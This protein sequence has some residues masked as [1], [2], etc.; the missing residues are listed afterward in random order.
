MSDDDTKLTRPTGGC[1]MNP[2]FAKSLP[3]EAMCEKAREIYE[4]ADDCPIGAGLAGT[5]AE[6][7]GMNIQNNVHWRRIR[8]LLDD[9]FIMKEPGQRMK[10]VY[11]IGIGIVAAVPFCFQEERGLVLY[12]SRSTADV[13]SL[14]HASNE[15]CLLGSTDLIGA[16]HV[17]R[18]ARK[19]SDERRENRH[20]KSL[21][22][23][24]KMFI[25]ETKSLAAMVLNKEDIEELR[26][27]RQREMEVSRGFAE[28]L[29]PRRLAARMSCAVHQFG[30]LI[31]KRIIIS[32]RKWGGAKLNGPPRKSMIDCLFSGTGAFLTMLALLKMNQSLQ[33]DGRIGFDAGWYTSTLC[34]VFALTPASVG[35][36][37]HIFLAHLWNMLVGLACREIPT[38][39][40]Y[41]LPLMWVQALAVALGISGQA[42]IGNLH[43][44]ATGLSMIFASGPKWT[45]STIVAVMLADTVVVII[46]ML[47]INLSE[48]GQYP[49]YWVGLGWA[50][51]GGTKGV[52]KSKVRSLRRSIAPA[53][54]QSHDGLRRRP[55]DG[56]QYKTSYGA[57]SDLPV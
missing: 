24:R 35:Q 4:N 10:R 51:G 23:A 22:T 56:D 47:Y 17:I 33:V 3:S 19:E 38:T 57:I 32:R 43:P 44:P 45:W 37:R 55:L 50:G 13:D 18:N 36:P 41:G 14:R 15:R 54:K 1:W 6:E 21:R 29:G 53:S 11:N 42:Y 40:D 9:P 8:S 12:F 27:Q 16:N 2:I 5:M 52:V 34:I 20:R 25:K 26:K 48:R 31:M 30:K 46:S 39:G 7:G 49:M 28:K